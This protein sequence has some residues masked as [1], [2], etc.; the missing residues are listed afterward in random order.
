[1]TRINAHI[2]PQDLCDQH[3][4]AEYREILRVIT[5]SL[6]KADKK[7]KEMLKEVPS[8]FKLGGGHVTFFYDKLKYIHLRFESI[9]QELIK[10]KFE[11]SFDFDDSKLKDYAWLYHDW[12]YDEKARNLIIERIYERSLTMKRISFSKQVKTADEYLEILRSS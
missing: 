3:L 2:P 8:E 4:L 12:E 11:V 5:L 10:R 7:G 1:M 6:R 9:R